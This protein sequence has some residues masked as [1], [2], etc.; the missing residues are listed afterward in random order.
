MRRTSR[1]ALELLGQRLTPAQ[2]KAFFADVRAHDDAALSRAAH[3]PAPKAAAPART[4]DA[5]A[6][7]VTAM[8]AP[9]LARSAEKAHMLV[10]HLEGLVGRKLDVAPEAGL[11]ASVRALRRTLSDE[12]IR[13]GAYGLRV[14]LQRDY[15]LKQP[16]K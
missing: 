4:R 6:G 10:T 13:D 7:E 3:P 14:A 9:V 16:V 1:A 12:E 2:L 11:A 8:L 15:S 5:L